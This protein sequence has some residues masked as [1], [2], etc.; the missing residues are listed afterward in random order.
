L[1]AEIWD[2]LSSDSEEEDVYKECERASKRYEEILEEDKERDK[3][4]LPGAP[5]PACMCLHRLHI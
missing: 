4:K 1:E 3:E 2:L 5:E